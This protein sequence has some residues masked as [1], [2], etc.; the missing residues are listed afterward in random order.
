[1]AML[2]ITR[3]QQVNHLRIGHFYSKRLFF[4]GYAG[5]KEHQKQKR[6]KPGKDD[7]DLNCSFEFWDP[8][9]Q[10]YIMFFISNQFNGHVR[11]TFLAPQI[12]IYQLPS[13]NLLQ[14]ANWKDPP[15]FSGEN[16]R[17]FYGHWYIHTMERSTIFNG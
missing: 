5:P 16:S 13:G 9:S 12:G 8:F 14:F 17:T 15:Y 1:M 10:F 2:V 11:T 4:E 3:W 7:M 6:L